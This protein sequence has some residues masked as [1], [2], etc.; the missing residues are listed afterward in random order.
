MTTHI[1]SMY[2]RPLLKMIFSD[3][4]FKLMLSFRQV[5]YHTLHW[6]RTPVGIKAHTV[7]ISD[8]LSE[9][10]PNMGCVVLAVPEVSPELCIGCFSYLPSGLQRHRNVVL[11]W[12]VS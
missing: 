7:R 10:Q 5:K 4:I 3:A 2:M 9:I 6:P 8:P 11:Y 1:S 12:K